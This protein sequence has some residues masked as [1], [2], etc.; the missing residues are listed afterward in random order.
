[1]RMLALVLLMAVWSSSAYAGLTKQQLDNVALAP[2]EGARVSMTLEFQ[3]MN[4]NE[5]SLSHAIDGRPTVLLPA[6]FTCT[7]ICGPALTIVASALQ[8][9]GLAAGRDYSVVVF[10][11]DAGD[12]PA[13]AR[14]FVGGQVGGPGVSV[15]IGSQTA[16]DH[17]TTTIG[18]RFETDGQNSAVAHPAAFVTL[19]PDGHVSHAFSSLGLQPFDLKLGLLEAGQGGIGGLRSRIALLCYGFD[20]VHGIYT[21]RVDFALKLGCAFTVVL[22]AMAI[23]IM[24]RRSRRTGM[25]A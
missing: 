13:A 8:Q 3:D 15:L 24:C 17:L 11:I 6:D 22:L 4:G 10:G 21:R 9:T 2:P 12:D 16:I 23:T 1:M 19:T 5:T 20:P 18:Y 25:I 14:R 7:E